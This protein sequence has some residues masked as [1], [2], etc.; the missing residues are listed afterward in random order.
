MLLA[1]PLQNAHAQQLDR[2]AVSDV[3]QPTTPACPD[4]GEIHG[5]DPEGD[6]FLAVRTGPGTDHEQVDALH[7]G[8][9]VSLCDYR[10]GWHRV[11]YSA[12]A[13]DVAECSIKS[14][15]MQARESM[16]EPCR[17]GWV[18]GNWVRWIWD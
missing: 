1:L 16:A 7:N 3:G 14:D 2:V 8:D 13:S 18:H 4:R 5:L 11:V 15:Q 10:N 9:V 17:S 6:G 12:R